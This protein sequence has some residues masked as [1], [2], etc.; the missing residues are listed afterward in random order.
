MKNLL[1]LY[2]HGLGDCILLTPALREFYK[3][4]GYKVSIA[5][6]KRFETAELFAHNPYIKN[7]YFTNDAWSDYENSNIGF[8]SL[9]SEWKAFAKNNDFSGFVICTRLLFQK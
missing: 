3:T 5:M 9:H 8:R 2:P 7:L 6:L 1:I 4:T